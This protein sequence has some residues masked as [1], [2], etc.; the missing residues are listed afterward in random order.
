MKL[1]T[2]FSALF[3][4]LFTNIVYGAALTTRET[5]VA[6]S[7]LFSDVVAYQLPDGRRKIDFFDNGVLEGYAIETDD[8]G[9][10]LASSSTLLSVGKF[11]SC[12][13]LLWKLVF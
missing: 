13:G 2:V 4:A 6:T 9:M 8:G 3:L 10:S 1:I 12:L 11:F 7:S 5:D